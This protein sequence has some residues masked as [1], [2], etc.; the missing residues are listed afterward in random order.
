MKDFDVAG[1]T[2]NAENYCSGCIIEAFS[3]I[4]ENIGWE[5][6]VEGVLDVIAAVMKVNRDDENSFDSSEFPKRIMCDSA[7]NAAYFAQSIAAQIHDDSVEH[8]KC[9]N[10]II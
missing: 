8:C 5:W 6:S 2:Y 4:P 9:G 3:G 10:T 7:T 1:Y